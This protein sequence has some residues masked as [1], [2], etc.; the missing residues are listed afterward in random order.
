MTNQQQT[1]FGYPALRHSFRE[2]IRVDEEG[3]VYKHSLRVHWA[4]V[5]A[6]R[7][8]PDFLFD[9][10][11]AFVLSAKRRLSLYLAD[12]RIIAIRGD[13]LRTKDDTLNP[14]HAFEQLR[15]EV[16]RRNVP[17]WRGPREEVILLATAWVLLVLGGTAGAAYAT[18]SQAK[19]GALGA[20]VVSGVLTSQ[21]AFLLAPAIGRRARRIYIA[22]RSTISGKR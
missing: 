13:L 14:D 11:E 18:W 5:V 9:L 3:F 4:E 19:A 6:Y 2:I 21:F 16:E 1:I 22:A 12:G 15:N 8:F 17:K 10:V 7:A 20:A